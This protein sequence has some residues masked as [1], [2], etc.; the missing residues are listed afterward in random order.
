MKEM[1]EEGCRILSEMERSGEG[2]SEEEE[3]EERYMCE[4]Y[5]LRVR[6]EQKKMKESEVSL[7]RREVEGLRR[8]VE[9]EK[10]NVE[11]EKKRADDAEERIRNLEQEMSEVNRLIPIRS[12]LYSIMM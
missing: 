6:G 2:G 4:L 7:L 3:E 12:L 1:Y 9:E 5:L 11:E 10:K 8:E